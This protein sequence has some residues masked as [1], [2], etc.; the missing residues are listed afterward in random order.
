MYFPT[1]VHLRALLWTQHTAEALHSC[2]ANTITTIHENGQWS[3]D[4]VKDLAV[5]E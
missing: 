2:D 3:V 1:V 5:G 4:N